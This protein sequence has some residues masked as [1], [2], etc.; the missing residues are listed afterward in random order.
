D[1]RRSRTAA[2]QKERATQHERAD[3][4][5]RREAEWHGHRSEPPRHA[6]GA[7][8]TG[9]VDGVEGGID[10]P[11]CKLVTAIIEIEI[12]KAVEVSLA[13]HRGRPPATAAL[14]SSASRAA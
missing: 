3:Q 6:H 12:E 9:V 7:L 2:G 11:V 14:R 1:R 10:P 8:L 13:G 5:G 4:G